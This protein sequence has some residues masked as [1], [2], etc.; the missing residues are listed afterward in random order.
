MEFKSPSFCHS[1]S[2]IRSRGLIFRDFYCFTTLTDKRKMLNNFISCSPLLHNQM[3]LELL[4]LVNRRK[5]YGTISSEANSLL[6]TQ[7]YIA[8]AILSLMRE[9]VEVFAHNQLGPTIPYQYQCLSF[10]ALG[11]SSLTR[12]TK[13]KAP[14]A[15]CYC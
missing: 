3:P 15:E 1:R 6:S 8:S 13:P 4:L 9:G 5:A 2:E 12:V 11:Q 7:G 10:T 14:H